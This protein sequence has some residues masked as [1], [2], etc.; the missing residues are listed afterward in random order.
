MTMYYMRKHV[1]LPVGLAP[2][3][4]KSATIETLSG[5]PKRHCG[6]GYGA[7]LYR[8]RDGGEVQVI[9]VYRSGCEGCFGRF[10]DWNFWSFQQ[11]AAVMGIGDLAWK[12]VVLHEQAFKKWPDLWAVLFRIELKDEVENPAT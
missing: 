12:S 10:L 7:S 11:Q 9:L 5:M 1:A 2:A 8:R 3:S 4:S 6:K